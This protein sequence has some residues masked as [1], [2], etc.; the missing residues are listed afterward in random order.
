MPLTIEI[1]EKHKN[2]DVYFETGTF[3]GC[4]I[5][6]A[7][8]AGFKEIYSVEINKEYVD[9]ANNRHKDKENVSVIHS[10]SVSFLKS[11]IDTKRC[12]IF[13]DAHAPNTHAI[14]D[15]LEAISKFKIKNHIIAV[16]DF[17]LFRSGEFKLDGDPKTILHNKILDINGD[18][19]IIH[20]DNDFDVEDVIIGK[21]I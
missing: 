16:D 7:Y 9:F 11:V 19:H 14:T 4:G 21:L 2:C 6:K 5:Q 1:I 17:R 8:D 13:L 20:E 10:D 18:Y 12:F 3:R 15:E